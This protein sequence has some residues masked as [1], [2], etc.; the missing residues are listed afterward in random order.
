MSESQP[1]EIEF[2]DFTKLDLRTA[3]VV[4]AREHPNADRLLLLDVKIGD[5]Q[6]QIVAGLRGHYEPQELVGK[7]IIVVV[8]LKPRKMRGEESQGMLLAASDQDA[9]Q[10]VLLTTERAVASG[11]KV[12]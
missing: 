1:P 9:S 3:T 5:V 10:I 7:T 12:T 6:R 8:N 2:D 4:Q 11:L